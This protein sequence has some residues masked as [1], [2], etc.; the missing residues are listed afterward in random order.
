MKK[1]VVAIALLL[2]G[3]QYTAQTPTAGGGVAFY[4]TNNR[5]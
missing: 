3:S 5:S 1:T 2:A 4:Q